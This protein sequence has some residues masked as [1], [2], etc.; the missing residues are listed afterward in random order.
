MMSRQAEEDKEKLKQTYRFGIKLMVALSLPI[1]VGFTVLA[2]IL[3][4]ILAGASYLPNGAIALTIMIWSIPIGWMNSLTQ[5]ALIALGLQRY[6]TRAFFFAVT[7]NIVTNIIFI[8]I[9]GFAAAAVTTILS[10]AAL[11]I[12][13]AILMHRGLEQRI[14]WLSLIWRPVIATGV[15]IGAVFVL[16][17][18]N[19][20]LALIVA[21]IVYLLILLMLNPLDEN[22]RAIIS[23][24]L[25]E[26]VKRLPFLRIT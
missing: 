26:R 10:E 19:M 16:L 1:A 25:P 15:M 22:E 6:I 2:N 8:P 20:L 12:P 14:N 13:F 21:S 18:I 9:Y 23:P 24:M 11:L 17:Q 3:T 7:F 5:Y 4:L